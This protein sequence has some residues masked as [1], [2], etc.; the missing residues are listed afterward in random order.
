MGD[1]GEEL[2][3]DVPLDVV[4]EVG[5]DGDVGGLD[6]GDA[7]VV[8]GAA[9]VGFDHVRR[10]RIGRLAVEDEDDR[11][12][13]L[14]AEAVD[15][16]DH[17]VMDSVVERFAGRKQGVEIFEGEGEID[18]PVDPALLLGVGRVERKPQRLQRTRILD[19]H[20]DPRIAGDEVVG[21]RAGVVGEGEGDDGGVG[22]VAGE[23]DEGA[24]E[25]A[26][27][28]EG[29]DR[30]RVLKDLLAGE[31]QVD[32]GEGEI[33]EGVG[34]DDVD[35][36]VGAGGAAGAAIEHDPG[37]RFRGADQVDP[38]AGGV[39]L[40][41]SVFVGPLG[42]LERRNQWRGSV[43][44]HPQRQGA[45]AEIAGKV[46]GGRRDD[47]GAVD[48]EFVIE[49]H[50]PIDQFLDGDL[51][52]VGVEMEPHARFGEEREVAVRHEGHVIVAAGAGVVGRGEV[53]G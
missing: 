49:F 17:D 30:E 16:L 31:E 2:A 1:A 4:A 6:T 43:D 46:L 50:R 18:R 45:V 34:A 23:G 35:D 3:V 32:F 19:E 52:A 47:V 14:L 15:R 40:A 9:I 8:V 41:V 28:V 33:A 36:G 44:L 7:V 53:G 12:E 39:V 51:F 5:V 20:V 37:V 22:V 10:R 29:F 24:A 38:L 42:E 48:Q 27:R 25:V 26:G 11:A 21:A 13:I